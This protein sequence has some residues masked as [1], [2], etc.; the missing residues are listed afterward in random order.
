[1]DNVPLVDGVTVS[2]IMCNT[3]DDDDCVGNTSFATLEVYE[4]NDD[5][6]KF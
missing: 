6:I 5:D 4:V 2:I 3:T 1:M